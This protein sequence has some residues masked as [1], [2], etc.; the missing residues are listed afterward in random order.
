MR[1]PAE[2]REL[3]SAGLNA[4][5]YSS[6]KKRLACSTV[7]IL[8]SLTSWGRASLPSAEVT[9]TTSLCL[10]ESR[11]GSSVRPDPAVPVPLASIAVDPPSRQPWAPSVRVQGAEQTLCVPSPRTAPPSPSWS[12]PHPPNC[13]SRSRWWRRPESRSSRTSDHPGTTDGGCHRCAAT[14]RPADISLLIPP[15]ISCANDTHCEFCLRRW[16]F[17]ATISATPPDGV[18]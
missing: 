10:G 12:I 11:P 13:A 14:C 3:E 4:A 5:I 2:P 18:P 7:P 1:Y 6:R 8:R 9:L 17:M 16:R 15:D